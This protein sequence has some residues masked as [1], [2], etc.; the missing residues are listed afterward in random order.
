MLI[1]FEIAARKYAADLSRG[2]SLAI[3]LRFDGPQPSFFGAP[4]AAAEAVKSGAWVGD[5]RKGGSCNVYRYQLVP[6]CNGT[7]TECVGH[8]VEDRVSVA[9]CLP[10]SLL[11]A[12]LVSVV[13]RDMVI[14]A[15]L[16][17]AALL[18]HPQ[19]GFHRS[20]VIRTLPNGE[21]K[22]SRR[23]EGPVPAAYL[24]LD[25]AELLVRM[26]VEHLLLDVPSLDPAEDEGRMSA[27]RV[28]WDMPTDSRSLADVRR[29]KATVT[30]MIYVPESV[31]DG[32]YLLDLQ[33]PA[34]MTDAA[35]SRPVIYPVG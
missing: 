22:L 11:P 21:D 28:F 25:A 20:V 15:T 32:Y 30:E 31:S 33:I 13:P 7:H 27:H 8:M 19:T 18:R 26:G 23:Y 3:P 29:P 17:H 34:F 10:A 6:H 1:S 12:T 14:D 35:P 9:D 24:G 16:L 2:I 5:V 4:A